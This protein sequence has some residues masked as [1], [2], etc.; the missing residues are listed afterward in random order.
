MLLQTLV[1][2]NKAHHLTHARSSEARDGIDEGLRHPLRV[3][4]DHLLRARHDA[5]E[6][7]RLELAQVAAVHQQTR[8]EDYSAVFSFED[9]LRC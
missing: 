3:A 8:R 5:K 6:V 1:A 2:A 7:V 4:V 9:R